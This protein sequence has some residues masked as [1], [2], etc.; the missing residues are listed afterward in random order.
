MEPLNNKGQDDF[1]LDRYELEGR[2]DEL[3]RRENQ[4]WMNKAQRVLKE[5]EDLLDE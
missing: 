2:L 5:M 1:D 4:E 3:K